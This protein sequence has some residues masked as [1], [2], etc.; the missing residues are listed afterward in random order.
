MV[1]MG[2]Q[3]ASGAP[4]G[5]GD[6]PGSPPVRPAGGMGTYRRA[7]VP[8]V[9]ACRPSAAPV[10]DTATYACANL[11]TGD[12]RQTTLARGYLPSVGD[13]TSFLQAYGRFLVP[14]LDD[15]P[16]VQKAVAASL[17]L[18][19]LIYH[20][21]PCAEVGDVYP[22]RC[23]SHS[24]LRREEGRPAN[25]SCRAPPMSDTQRKELAV[26]ADVKP[27]PNASLLQTRSS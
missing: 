7:E 6:S 12:P 22:K 24:S 3:R 4:P 5:V 9:P 2:T 18:D 13:E 21:L 8:S 20:R 19:F 15:L 17:E 26:T 16:R 10:P 1:H 11:N 23:V 25:D 14:L 27:R